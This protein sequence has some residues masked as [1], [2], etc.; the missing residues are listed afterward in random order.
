MEAGFRVTIEELALRGTRDGVRGD[1]TI[2]SYPGP[3]GVLG[4]AVFDV[5]VS[6]TYKADGELKPE[7]RKAGGVAEAGEKFKREHYK[8]IQC[9]FVPLCVEQFGTQGE[10]AYAFLDTVAEA[11]AAKALGVDLE[12]ARQL[13]GFFRAQAA[14]NKHCRMVISV[15]I[16]KVQAKLVI[17]GAES[18]RLSQAQ[19]F[20]VPD[21]VMHA[22]AAAG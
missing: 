11:Q 16:A 1:F 7:A 17:K 20:G 3:D 9:T 18:V 10:A 8:G 6:S 12:S 19:A 4:P 5:R 22:A 13:P 15:A 2:D 14:A 21:P